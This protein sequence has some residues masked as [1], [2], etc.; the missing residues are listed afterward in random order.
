ME[1]D[2]KNITKQTYELLKTK[3]EAAII[4]K[5]EFEKRE[6][7]EMVRYINDADNVV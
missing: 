6:A 3:R 4:H 2:V 5:A 7:Y 1:Y